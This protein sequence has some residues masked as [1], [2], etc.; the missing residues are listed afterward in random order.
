[1]DLD[2]LEVTDRA[3]VR[4]RV[5][6]IR[7][8]WRSLFRTLYDFPKPTIAAV[9]RRCRSP[10]ARVWRLC[11]DFTLAVPEAKFG[12]TEVRIGFVPAIVSTFLLAPGGRKDRARPCFSPARLFDAAEAQRIGLINEIVAAEQLMNRARELAAQLME[13]SPASLRYTKATAQ[14]MRHALNSDMQIEAAVR[15][16]A[17]GPLDGRTSAKASRRFSRSAN[18]KLEFRMSES[19]EPNCRESHGAMKRACGC[20]TPRPTRWAWSI[21]SN[22][23]IWFEMGRVELLA[24]ARL[25]VQRYGS[26]MTAASSRWWT[27]AAA[28][29]LRRGMTTRLLLRTRLKN[30]RES[31]IHF[32]YELVRS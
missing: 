2:N 1:M 21:T 6:K 17:R 16:N 15:E 29:R 5:W 32:G 22:H 19:G 11:C 12:Y 23:F 13:N 10:A 20:A 18:R 27:R 30:I 24:A 26:S 28:T 7:R 9:N 14:A 4:N 8:Q 25:F 3:H 31:V